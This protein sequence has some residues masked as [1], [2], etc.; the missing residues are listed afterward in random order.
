MGNIIV[1]HLR[2]TEQSSTTTRGGRSTNK[3]N[4]V[5]AQMWKDRIKV[6]QEK[7]KQITPIVQDVVASPVADM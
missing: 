6:Y 2:T 7:K 3:S 1:S 4:V 5:L